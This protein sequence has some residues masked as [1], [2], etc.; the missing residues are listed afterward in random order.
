MSTYKNSNTKVVGFFGQSGSGKTT[1]IKGMPSVVAGKPVIQETGTIRKLFSKNPTT[2]RNPGEFVAQKS[3]IMS[4]GNPG[5]IIAQMYEKYIKSQFQLLNDYST[6]VF[7]GVREQSASPNFILFDRC[8]LDFHVLT[9]CGM[10]HLMSEFGGKLNKTHSLFMSL[11][12]KTACENTANFFD[13][14]FIIKPW[15]TPNT[16]N[17]NAFT[18]GVRDQYLSSHYV[19]DNWYSKIDGLDIGKTKVFVI[20]ESLISVD[21][22]VKM[23]VEKL[24][25]I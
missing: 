22:R 2:Y 20:D 7:M 11:A 15:T 6:E 12:K 5:S 23:V 19:G 10:S 8:P 13:A 18:D 9:E 1:I 14:I 17:I 24:K 4:E 25:E 3:Q 16:S 21:S